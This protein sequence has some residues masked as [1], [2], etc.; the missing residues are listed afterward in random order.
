M[1]I[2]GSQDLPRVQVCDQEGCA[3]HDGRGRD[4]WP[5]VDD[6]AATG[7]LWAA[8]GL[9]ACTLR[10]GGYADS[11]DAKRAQGREREA[12]REGADGIPEV[13]HRGCSLTAP[14]PGACCRGP[15]CT[16]CPMTEVAGA[17]TQIAGDMG[18]PAI[19]GF[20]P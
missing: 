15:A 14:D 5:Q 19:A 18:S 1:W 11:G 9:D 8:D 20:G 13:S 6:H 17:M 16:V 7:E 10:G 12:Q 3:R 2:P 4:S